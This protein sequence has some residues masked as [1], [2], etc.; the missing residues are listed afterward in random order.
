MTVE[1]QL[2]AAGRAVREQVRDLPPLDLPAQPVARRARART[3]LRRPGA[4]RWLIPMAA[5]AAVVVV[6][7]TLVAV[8]NPPRATHNASAGP[9]ASRS[10][11]AAASTRRVA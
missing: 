9:A 8:K 2:R 1:E 5:A 6:A 11:G 7:V 3:F 10:T 4:G